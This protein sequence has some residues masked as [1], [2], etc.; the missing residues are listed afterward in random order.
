MLGAPLVELALKNPPAVQETWVQS[1]RRGDPLKKQMASHSSILAW[2]EEPGGSTG[3]DRRAW[4]VHG[5][6]KVSDST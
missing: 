6:A 2:K 4:W 5:V 1:W 3:L